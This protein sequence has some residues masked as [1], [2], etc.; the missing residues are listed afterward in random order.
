MH[1]ATI[2]KTNFNTQLPQCRLVK[3]HT[4]VPKDSTALIFRIIGLVIFENQL[5]DD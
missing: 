4:N 1:G 3:K 5:L 2:K